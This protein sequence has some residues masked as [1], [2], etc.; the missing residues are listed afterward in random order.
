MLLV[1]VRVLTVVSVAL[2]LVPTGAHLFELPR[3]M[4]MS[5][6]DYMVVQT[7]YSGWSLFGIVIFAAMLLTLLHAILRRGQ[8]VVLLLSLAAL[9]CLVAT[10]VVFWMF[11]YPMNVASSNWTVTP[12]HFETARRQWEYSHAASAVLAFLALV[13][14]A[15]AVAIDAAPPQRRSSAPP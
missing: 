6:P 10:Q 11:T 4:A 7:I 1:C 2:Y 14:I 12:E 13:A 3:K 9:L 8:R 15:W 5:P